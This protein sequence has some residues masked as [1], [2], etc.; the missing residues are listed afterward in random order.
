MDVVYEG[1]LDL[2]TD[3][4]PPD[5]EL[6]LP[7]GG[8]CTRG[9]GSWVILPPE[10]LEVLSSSDD[11]IEP[12]LGPD[13]LTL[14]FASTRSGI[15][16]VYEASRPSRSEPFGQPTPMSGI[17]SGFGDTRFAVSSD[18]LS[19]YLATDRPGGPGESDLWMATRT[20]IS[21]PWDSAMFSPMDI[22]TPTNDW[23]PFPSA[24]GLR[25]Y[26][27]V[28]NDPAGAGQQDL[29]VAERGPPA[30]PFANPT[31][32]SEINTADVEDNATL[33]ADEL[34]IVFGSDRPGGQGE[35]DIWYAVRSNVSDPFSTPQPMPVVNSS[36]DDSETTLSLDGCELFFT[37]E[38]Q[39]GYDQ[40]LYRAEVLA[41]P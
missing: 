18:E 38:R 26:W 40:D 8:G 30:D 14:Y 39:S 29:F 22:S 41:S 32:L 31:P 25:L 15:Y 10:R 21:Q 37:S 20:S 33:T 2:A 4:V 24:N 9:T 5:L 27:V 6:P 35:R 11:D 36:F 19:A 7:D 12:F 1:Q 17:N 13:G 3:S 28:R 34:V 16:E 23:D